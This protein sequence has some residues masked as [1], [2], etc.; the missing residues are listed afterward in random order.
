MILYL[1]GF[2]SSPKSFKA[3]VVG[4]GDE[5]SMDAFLKAVC[6]GPM[7]RYIEDADCQWSNFCGQFECFSIFT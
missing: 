2:R 1:H 5:E 6:E 3:R 4:E 7:C